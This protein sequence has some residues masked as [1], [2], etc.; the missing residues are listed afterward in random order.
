VPA[1]V[2]VG[3]VQALVVTTLAQGADSAIDEPREVVIRSADEW[4]ALWQAHRAEPPPP[5][6]FSQVMVVGL[7]AGSRP[8][9]GFSVTITSVRVEDGRLMVEWTEQRPAAGDLVAQMITAPFHLVT[10]PR[11]DGGVEFRRSPP[12]P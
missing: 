9:A 10:V 1:W 11:T 8:T 12:L 3:V 4:R 7:F 2:V 5:V 6:D